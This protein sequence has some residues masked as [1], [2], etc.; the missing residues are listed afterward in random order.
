L[1]VIN[2]DGG[3][4]LC[5]FEF[6]MLDDLGEDRIQGGSRFTLTGRSR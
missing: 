4:G 1:Q 5:D 6:F 2:R 3:L